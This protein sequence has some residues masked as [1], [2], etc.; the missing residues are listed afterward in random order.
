MYHFCSQFAICGLEDYNPGA[1]GRLEA[2]SAFRVNTRSYTSGLRIDVIGKPYIPRSIQPGT[3]ADHE[4]IHSALGDVE[5]VTIIPGPGYGGLTRLRRGSILAALGPHAMGA[6]GTGWDVRVAQ[7][8]GHRGGTG[9]IQQEVMRRHE[10]VVEIGDELNRNGSMN[11]EQVDAAKSR[12]RRKRRFGVSATV[13][14]TTEDGE[15]RV[16]E[17]VSIRQDGTVMIP[18]EWMIL[19]TKKKNKSKRKEPAFAG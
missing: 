9:H 2:G 10:E 12:A 5:H 16:V 11:G 17:G 7:A 13:T 18:G 8:M 4:A 14:M 6:H 1:M 15:L 3:T 19:P